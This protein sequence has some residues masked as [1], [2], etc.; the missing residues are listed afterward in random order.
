M[1]TPPKPVVAVVHS[2]P[3]RLRVRLSAPPGDAGQMIAFVREHRG[4]DRIEYT[5]ATQSLLIRFD[6]HA[7]STEEISLRAA[8]GYAVDRGGPVRLLAAP[9]QVVLQDSA[10]LA[11][12]GL[13]VALGTR[14]MDGRASRPPRFDWLAGL[15]TAWSVVEHAW[16]ELRQRGYFD[17]EVLALAY[18]VGS[19]VRGNVLSAS[20]VTWL[21]TFGRHLIEAPATGVQVQPRALPGPSGEIRHEIV[22]A[23]DTDAPDR[24]RL[25]IVGLM[26][27]ALKYAMTGGGT[28]G[29]RNLWEELREVARVHGEV[30]E[31]YG[32]TPEGIPVRFR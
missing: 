20:A 21:T 9:E 15:C 4:M 24:L 13:L 28:H 8:F 12:V 30:L 26:H 11:G 17:P 23:P 2:L 25:G 1:R 18:L 10:V 27:G 7:I 3:G 29:Y 14:W 16:R 19:L 5:P 31:G 32:R 6:P 22:V